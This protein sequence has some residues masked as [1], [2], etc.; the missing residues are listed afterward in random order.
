MVHGCCLGAVGGTAAGRVVFERAHKG[1]VTHPP[2]IAAISD[3]KKRR[4]TGGGN[5]QSLSLLSTSKIRILLEKELNNIAR[6]IVDW[7]TRRK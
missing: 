5:G 7:E 4:R 6:Q 3:K 2:A 1:E